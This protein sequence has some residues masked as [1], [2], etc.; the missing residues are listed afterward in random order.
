MATFLIAGCGDVGTRLGLRLAGRG[1]R[2]F[3]LRRRPQTLPS[4]LEPLAA[5]LTDRQGLAAALA[6]LPAELDAVAY[7]AAADGHSDDAYHRAYVLGVRRLLAALDDAG[8]RPERLVFASSTGVYGQHDGSWVDETSPT[9]PR[10][11]TGRR[12]LEGEE[13]CRAGPVPSVALRLGGIYGPG[14]TR[15]LD[16]VAAGQIACPGGPPI[17]TNRIHSD[18]AAGALAH[19]LELEAP[20]PIY[21]GVDC[22]PAERSEVIRFLAE[23][24]G[25]P[26]PPRQP[27]EEGA[28]PHGGSKRCSNRRLLESGYRFLYPTYRE[29]YGEM[30]RERSGL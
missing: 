3:G 11:F 9:E 7:A 20:L 21:L 23:C 30:L 27:P 16:R 28:R 13:V 4:P 17:Y 22:E 24:L 25:A 5:D 10:G 8:R 29:G 18:D 1:H 19:L 14:R 6:H 2:V 15:L 12:V 26:P